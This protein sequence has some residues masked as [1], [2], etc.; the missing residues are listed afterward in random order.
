MSERNSS[1]DTLVD[2]SLPAAVRKSFVL[3]VGFVA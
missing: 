2:S 1:G 3:V